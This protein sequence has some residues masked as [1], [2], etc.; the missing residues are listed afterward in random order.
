MKTAVKEFGSKLP[1]CIED[2]EIEAPYMLKLLIYL[3]IYEY[4]NF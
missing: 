2:N 3:H 4:F 1:L